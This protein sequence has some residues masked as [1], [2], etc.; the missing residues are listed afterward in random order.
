MTNTPKP[1]NNKG[2]IKGFVSKFKPII[3]H[4]TTFIQRF[5]TSVIALAFVSFLMNVSTSI[6]TATATTFVQDVLH[7]GV[8]FLIT[9]RC[10]A[11]GFSYFIKVIV[12]V[13]SDLTK[14]RKVFLML[15]YGGVLIIKPL[16]IIVS[17]GMFTNKTNAI[18]YAI[19]QISDRLLNATRD[20]PRDSL[21]AD[22]TEISL[23][24]QSFGLRR[25]FASL[26]SQVGGFLALVVTFITA[27]YSIL[28]TIASLPA[29]YSVYILYKNVQE[30]HKTH[31]EKSASWFSLGKL[32]E[33][34]EKLKQ[35]IFFMFIIF[36]LSFG[37]FNE[38]CL[39]QVANNLGY[40]PI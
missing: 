34:K 25:C 2:K 24:T 22:A 11:E 17:L 19:A 13:F 38:I 16:F 9:V 5:P 23:R 6:V 36:I 40:N 21:I 27:K 4:L 37:K 3:L 32:M 8:S 35:Y 28:Y 31:E 10:L 29:F 30:P 15:G 33:E 18:I 39:F 26:G 7:N 14:K 12:G 20:T 1:H